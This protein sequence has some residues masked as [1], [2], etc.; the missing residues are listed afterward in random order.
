MRTRP[1]KRAGVHAA[2][3]QG[4]LRK[5]ALSQTT[6]HWLTPNSRAPP[7]HRI[8]SRKVDPKTGTRRKPGRGRHARG[9]RAAR[10][11][12]ALPVPA[13]GAQKVL[14]STASASPVT[15]AIEQ[16]DI[17]IIEIRAAEGPRGRRRPARSTARRAG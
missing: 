7:S 17:S 13:L 1:S 14:L 12:R 6:L 5:P 16:R 4:C 9:G 15:E 11:R 2:S 3:S 10:A 8:Y